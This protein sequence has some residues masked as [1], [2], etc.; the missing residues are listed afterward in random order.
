M[1]YVTVSA[2]VR[3]EFLEVLKRYRVNVSKV[4]RRALEEKLA[5]RKE[6]AG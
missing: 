4:I 2:K 3:R 5:R 1:K 6:A